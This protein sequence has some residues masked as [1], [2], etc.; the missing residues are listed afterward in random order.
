MQP[1][2][3][4]IEAHPDAEGPLGVLTVVLTELISHD[5]TTRLHLRLRQAFTALA[6]V[7]ESIA[8]RLRA[9]YA[10]L[11]QQ[12]AE[13]LA[14]VPTASTAAGQVDPNAAAVSLVAV[15]EGLAYYVLIAVTD[16]GQARGAVLAAIDELTT[17]RA[18]SE[19]PG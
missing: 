11:H 13:L 1:G 16:P 12:L 18:R 9:D 19:P 8:T 7:D 2:A 4:Q 10:R 5:K 3:F 6:L 15:T 14:T 17:P